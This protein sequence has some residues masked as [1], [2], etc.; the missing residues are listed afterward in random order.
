MYIYNSCINRKIYNLFILNEKKEINK[1]LDYFFKLIIVKK[2]NHLKL[3]LAFK[4]V[5]VVFF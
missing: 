3:F 4:K 2:L 5:S 1:F